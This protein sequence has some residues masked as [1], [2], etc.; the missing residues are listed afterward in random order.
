MGRVTGCGRRS[1]ATFG[2]AAVR[3]ITT[4]GHA[5]HAFR[6]DV[7]RHGQGSATRFVRRRGSELRFQLDAF[8]RW[9]IEAEGAFG[10]RYVTYPQLRLR[11]CGRPT[12]EGDPKQQVISALRGWPYR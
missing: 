12:I 7:L 3:A 10:Y 6:P 1:T 8:P 11:D 5:Y 2:Q 4:S 9:S